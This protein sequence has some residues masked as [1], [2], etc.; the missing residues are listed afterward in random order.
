MAA[1]YHRAEVQARKTSAK[2][3]AVFSDVE[4]FANDRLYINGVETKGVNLQSWVDYGYQQVGGIHG[5]AEETTVGLEWSS[6][7]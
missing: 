4:S 2:M 6:V 3:K 5:L 1:S 7:T